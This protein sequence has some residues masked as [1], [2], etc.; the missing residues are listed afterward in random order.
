MG[1][2]QKTRLTLWTRSAGRCEYEGCNKPLLGDLLSGKDE[3][4][5]GY[6]AHIVAETPGG[7]RGDEKRSLE[8][9]DSVENLMLMCNAHHRLID[10]PQTWREYP[11]DRL[12]AMKAAH[13]RRIELVTDIQPDRSTHVLLYGARV[14]AHD[15]PVRYDLA[16]QALLPERYPAQREAI[17]LELRS[18]LA[19]HEPEYWSFQPPNLRRQFE[20][21]V[22]DALADGHVKHLSVFALAPQPLLIELGRLLSDMPEVGVHQLHREPQGWDWRDARAPIEIEITNKAGR[23]KA[24]GLVLSLSASVVDERITAVLGEDAPIWRV[25]TP[26]PHNDIMHRRDDLAAFRRAMRTVYDRIK[27]EHGQDATIHLFPA[28]PVSAAIEVGRTWMPK[29]DLPLVIYDENR[30]RGGFEPR[31]TIGN[32]AQNPAQKELSDA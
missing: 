19:D 17:T 27:A 6:V 5:D 4:N 31:L 10:H 11:E 25:T 23:G 24:V 3:L 7:P 1:V 2:S 13:E 16:K 28:L 12:L 18:D 20:R 21:K 30:T 14:G 26:Q 32:P 8:L 15:F 29:A 22:R 9:A